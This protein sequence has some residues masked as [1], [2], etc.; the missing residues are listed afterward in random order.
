MRGENL[1]S[2]TLTSPWTEDERRTALD[3]YDVTGDTDDADFTDIALLAAQICETSM[4][5]VTFL[6]PDGQYTKSN[7]GIN[8]RGF[9]QEQSFFASNVRSGKTM[10]VTDTQQDKRFEKSPFLADY[11]EIRF[12]AGAVIKNAMGVPLGAVCVLDTKTG[13]LSSDKVKALEVLARQATRL[14]NRRHLELARERE[15]R[16]RIMIMDSAIDYAIVS[17]DMNGTV[18]SWNAGAEIILGWTSEEAVGKDIDIFFTQEDEERGR[19]GKEME[20]SIKEGSAKDVRWHVRKGGEKFWADGRMM[21]LLDSTDTPRGF[22][23]I[24]RD[25][26]EQYY[27][28]KRQKDLSE[29]IVHRLKNTVTIVQSL[30][31]QTIRNSKTLAEAEK[32]VGE[33]LTSFANAQNILLQNDWS[34]ENIHTVMGAALK[35]HKDY[36]QQLAISGP[37]V[38][39]PAQQL[40]GFSLAI[41]EL[42]TNS[43]KHGAL[44]SDKGHIDISWSHDEDDAFAFHWKETGGPD[45]EEPKQ[46][47]FGSKILKSIT[48]S[49]FSG[50]SELGYKKAGFTYDLYGTVT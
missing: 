37:D 1:I 17:T 44:T 5:M 28:A 45:V 8:I 33:R 13:N 19:S 22:V 10:L 20:I 32:R 14:L 24:V 2:E 7:V 6:F 30:A 41:H 18:D 31:K 27:R 15:E 9:S 49:Y 43:I 12:Y 40:I 47:G 26:T 3:A 48:S 35:P 50:R 34:P 29:E 36:A 11:P 21:P 38:Q 23:K 46:N 16:L 39:L 4:A 25:K 42:M